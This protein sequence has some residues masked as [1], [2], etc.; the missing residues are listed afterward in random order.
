MEENIKL[1]ADYIYGIKPELLNIEVGQKFFSS[2][3][4]EIVATR[5]H[6]FQ[7]G[8]YDIYGYSISDGLP[9]QNYYPRDVKLVGKDITFIDII[10]LL[11]TCKYKYAHFEGNVL[12]IY[13]GEDPESIEWNLNSIY[14]K[15]QD[16]QM[17][18]YI[19]VIILYLKENEKYFN[20]TYDNK[21]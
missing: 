14:L 8:L 13:D 20:K 4:G 16:A 10:Y 6:K 11:K 7:G 3:Y 19:L 21:I 2:F 12:V 17:I 1:I 18:D 15:D 9:R 5:I